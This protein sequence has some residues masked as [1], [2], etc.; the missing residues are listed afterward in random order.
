VY[1]RVTVNITTTALGSMNYL[2]DGQTGD[3]TFDPYMNS[4]FQKYWHNHTRIR[5]WL[6][7]A[8]RNCE[9]HDFA[10]QWQAAPN[11][12]Y[13]AARYMEWWYSRALYMNESH[14]LFPLCVANLS[15]SFEHENSIHNSSPSVRNR[16]KRA[17]KSRRLSRRKHR[18]LYHD[19][20]PVGKLTQCDGSESDGVEFEFEMSDELLEF[21][22][23][24]AEHRK[25]RGSQ[26]TL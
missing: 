9:R 12:L 16:S 8:D 19:S 18:C 17:R 26:S 1:F 13:Q 2:Q 3:D 23:Q 24:T 10:K 21:F 6:A 14:S 22:K 11:Q 4:L 5:R 15:Q 20:V 25:E 7:E